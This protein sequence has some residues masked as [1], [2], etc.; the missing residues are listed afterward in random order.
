MKIRVEK[1]LEKHYDDP[2]I[3]A[4]EIM[5]E[6][7][8][9]AKETFNIENSMPDLLIKITDVTTP[10]LD[11]GNE[12]IFML[13]I[14]ADPQGDDEDTEPY[15]YMPEER[16]NF[17]KGIAERIKDWAEGD[18][19]MGDYAINLEASFYM[20]RSWHYILSACK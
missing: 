11:H 14:E 7:E 13:T 6:I 2:G 19:S 16:K 15:M 4:E 5:A 12:Y 3:W 8:K 20:N 9:R 10:G 18:A 1:E 17:W